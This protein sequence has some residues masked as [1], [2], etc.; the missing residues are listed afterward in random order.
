[1]AANHGKSM[2]KT[3]TQVK[4]KR[5]DVRAGR[6]DDKISVVQI[7]LTGQLNDVRFAA[8]DEKK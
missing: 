8:T 6:K 4:A 5:L 1:M 3:Y 7:A 2:S